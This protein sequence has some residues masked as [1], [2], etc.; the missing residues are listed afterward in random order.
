MLFWALIGSA[1]RPG[2]R[3]GGSFLSARTAAG[4]D[5]TCSQPT[6][7]AA[8]S[9][10]HVREASTSRAARHELRCS[11]LAVQALHA[12]IVPKHSRSVVHHHRPAN[13]SAMSD[14]SGQDKLLN[15]HASIALARLNSVEKDSESYEMLM[16]RR[17]A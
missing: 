16:N 2:R 17:G 7:R 11:V 12:S 13:A 6:L 15:L 10:H 3:S 8:A 14:I 4:D 5:I 1:T 9:V